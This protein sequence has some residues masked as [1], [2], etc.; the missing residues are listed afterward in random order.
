MKIGGMDMGVTTNT[1]LLQAKVEKWKRDLIDLM[2]R[3]VLLNFRP[4]K[5][6]LV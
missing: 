4:K 5:N 2:N 6:I 1:G 3:N